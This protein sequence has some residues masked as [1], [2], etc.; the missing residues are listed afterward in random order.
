MPPPAANAKAC[1]RNTI[2]LPFGTLFIQVVPPLYVPRP[3]L[4]HSRSSR[5]STCHSLIQPFQPPRPSAH[6]TPPGGSSDAG[7]SI[8]RERQG[9]VEW[10]PTW[11]Q[12]GSPQALSLRPQVR[13]TRL[14]RIPMRVQM[15]SSPPTSSLIV[16]FP[17]PGQRHIPHLVIVVIP[18]IVTAN[19]SVLSESLTLH[20]AVRCFRHHPPFTGKA[21]CSRAKAEPGFKP[22]R[23]GSRIHESSLPL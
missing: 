22:R 6:Q 15:S 4:S 1:G 23:S 2:L 19:D 16:S 10:A 5:L 18:V 12:P 14:R 21:I 7:P 8:P 20:S 3:E 13:A 9:A 11:R 17:R